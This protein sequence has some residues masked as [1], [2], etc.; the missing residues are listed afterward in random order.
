MET[1]EINKKAWN[2][3]TPNI[4]IDGGIYIYEYKLYR[5]H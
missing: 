4:N 5:E 2:H 1:N 3:A